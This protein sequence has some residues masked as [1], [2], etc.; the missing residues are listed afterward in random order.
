MSFQI[1]YSRVATKDIAKLDSIVK[2]RLKDKIEF[3]Q[4]DPLKFA[5]RLVKFNLGQ[6][7]WRV[8][9]YRVVFDLDE[10]KKIIV[11]LRVRHRKEVY[12]A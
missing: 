9:N 3:Y 4:Q 2:K 10:I 5:H 7:R 8:G 11:V 6:Y 1:I 12:R